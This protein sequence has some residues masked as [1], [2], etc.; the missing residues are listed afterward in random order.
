MNTHWFCLGALLLIFTCTHCQSQQSE[1]AEAETTITNKTFRNPI[2][3]GF[4]ADPSIC[5]RGEDYYLVNSS[6]AFYPGIPILHSK[7]LVHWTQIG[8]A[9]T[10]KSQIDLSV[11]GMSRGLYAPAI[12][13]HNGWFYI[14]CTEVDRG[15]NFIVKS[16]NPAGPYSD[17][18]WLPQI[19]GIDPS[20]FFDDDGKSYVVYNSVAPENTPAYQGHRSIRIHELKLETMQLTGEEQLL[21]NGGTN[22]ADEPIWIEGPHIYK[23]GTHYYLICAE[24]GTGYNHSE[25]VFRAESVLGPYE[26]FSDNPILTQRHLPIERAN[27]VTSTGHADLVQAPDGEWWAVFLGCR[28][29]T[30]SHYNTGRETFLAPVRWENGWPIINPDYDEVQHSYPTP[31]KRSFNSQTHL[32]NPLSFETDFSTA[33]DL[34]WFFLRTPDKDWLELDTVSQRLSLELQA[35]DIAGTGNPSLL[36]RRQPFLEGSASTYLEF[37]PDN[38]SEMA[39]FVILQNDRHYYFLNK[40]DATIQLLR[41]TAEGYVE[42]AAVPYTEDGVHLKITQEGAGYSFYYSSDGKQFRPIAEGIDATFLS[43]ETAGGFVGCMFGLYAT[44]NGMPSTNRATFDYLKI[45]ATD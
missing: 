24:G 28:P 26:S 17:P 3:P 8:A 20:L 10:R 22:L 32:P 27:P 29:Y 40:T 19:D 11:H 5:R 39:G 33:L 4:N 6:F 35:Q 21:I 30:G 12:S 45:K 34:R 15:G 16:E 14:V 23:L 36:L 1:Q 2:L 42:L 38:L 25:V 41:K 7:D 31:I 43:T 13:Y 37:T 44:S 9:I 18:F